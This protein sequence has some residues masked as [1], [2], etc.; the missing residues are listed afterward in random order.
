MPRTGGERPHPNRMRADEAEH[1]AED[2]GLRYATDAGPGLRRVRRGGG[3]AY[4]AHDGRPVR[5]ERTL[6]RIRALAVPPAWRDVWICPD[7]R[8]HVQATGRDARGRKQARYH[9]RWR[10]V[11]DGAKFERMLEF[12]RA[13]PSLR[14]RV[15]RDVAAGDLSRRCVVATVVRLLE[16][17][18]VRVGNDEYA[19]DN[20]SYGLTTL[21]DGHVASFGRTLRLS[22]VGKGGKPHEVEVSDPRAARVVRECRGLPG[23]RLFQWV[24]A[25]GACHAVSSEDV[26][27]YLRDA[28]GEDFTA[29]DFRTWAGT[30][31]ALKELAGA[32]PPRGVTAMR[33]TINAAVDAVAQRL[34]NTRAV[35]RRSY[36]HPAV[37]RAC[38]ERRL[39][40]ALADCDG[41]GPR[42]LRKDEVTALFFLAHEARAPRRAA[43]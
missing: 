22:F 30:V 17:T 28:C 34:R 10:E 7:A 6:A 21:R 12:G 26:N 13:L 9:A 23:R 41:R 35:C 40:D 3:F 33:R 16:T 29:K 15:A 42:G 8:G 11:R 39:V 5:D 2:A 32:P 43:A 24:D 18:L 25:D 1:D 37:L 38:E 31:L 36:V 4:L 14:S 27:A 19:R 20:H